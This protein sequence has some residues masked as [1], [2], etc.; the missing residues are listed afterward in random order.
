MT[1]LPQSSSDASSPSPGPSSPLVFESS[2][3]MLNGGSLSGRSPIGGVWIH[4]YFRLE[5]SRSGLDGDG[6]AG[7]AWS[8]GTV[9]A[10]PLAGPSQ[11]Q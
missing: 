7:A 10:V 8:N 2:A 11:V 9:T 5:V 3:S 4:A 1:Q 6:L